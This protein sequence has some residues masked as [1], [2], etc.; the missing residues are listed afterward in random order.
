MKLIL[1]LTLILII[2]FSCQ[3]K[4]YN[5]TLSGIVIDESTHLPVVNAKIKIRVSQ[6]GIIL[7]RST[8]YEVE[9]GYTNNKGKFNIKYRKE[10]SGG[11]YFDIN[12]DNFYEI[13]GYSIDIDKSRNY[14]IKLKPKAKLK[15][16]LVKTNKENSIYIETYPNEY[17]NSFSSK[18]DY[19][20]AEFIIE[21]NKYINLKR[22]IYKKN[23]QSSIKD[24]FVFCPSFKTTLIHI[25]Y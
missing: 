11:Y 9:E 17:R 18:S 19:D 2:H 23:G 20:E 12:A 7:G 21:G 14:E 25:Y 22:E 4:V 8:G 16:N 5:N 15:V 13:N 10:R 1:K 24:S 3:R 6:G